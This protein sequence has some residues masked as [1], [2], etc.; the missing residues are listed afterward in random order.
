M[1]VLSK[2]ARETVSRTAAR[3]LRTKL[4]LGASSR[5]SGALAPCSTALSNKLGA[6]AAQ[7]GSQFKNSWTSASVIRNFSTE[8]NTAS[9]GAEKMEFKAETKKLLNIVAK[10]LYTDKEVFIRELISNASDA[11]E[12]LRFLQTSG[13]APE[14]LTSKDQ[15]LQ[16]EL[17]C[18][19]NLRLFTIQDYGIGMT[20]EQLIHNLG[21]IARSGSREFLEQTSTGSGEAEQQN[22][23]IIGQFGVGFYSAFVVADK[24]EVL[25]RSADA[26]NKGYKWSSDGMGEFTIE[27]LPE[28]QTP[29]RGTK[30]QLHLKEDCSEFSKL[31]TVKSCAKKFSSFVDFPLFVQEEAG[32]MKE[33]NK[34]EPL[35]LKAKATEEEHSEFYRFLSGTSYGDPYYTLSFASD[36]PLTIKSLFYVPEDAP[37][38]FFAKE[39]E[40]GVALHCRRV[41][42]KKQAEGIMPRWLHWV[43]GVVDCEDMPLNISR[44][45][46]QDTAL[47]NK[48][49]LA[50]VRRFLRF[51]DQQAKKDA[52]KYL[53][54]YKN[55]SYY[56]KAGLIEDRDQGGRHKEE[57][58]KLLR[59]GVSTRPEGEL[60][61]LQ[62]Y[63]DNHMVSTDNG[64]QKNIYYY[65]VPNR[66]TAMNSPYMEQFQE[67]GRAVLLMH[68]DIDEFVLSS[69]LDGYK[70]HKLVAIDAQGK[71]FELD[72]DE[73]K[74]S[75]T[76]SGEKVELSSAQ[77]EEL[78]TWLKDTLGQKVMEIKFTDRLVSSPAIVTSMLTPHMRK[79]MKQ[80]MAAGAGGQGGGGADAVPMTLEIS[81]KHSI[82]KTLYSIKNSNEEVAKLSAELLFDNACIAAGML[83]EPRSVLPRLNKIL[84]TMVM[85]GA[86]YDYG[87]KE[88]VGAGGGA[89]EVQQPGENKNADVESATS[90][91]KGDAKVDEK[92]AFSSTAAGAAAE[93]SAT[94]EAVNDDPT[95]TNPVD[96][97]E[98]PIW[99]KREASG[100]ERLQEVKM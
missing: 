82:V 89:G 29:A 52:Q 34:Q 40:I 43:K 30:I 66:E 60:I 50:V 93:S 32:K 64:K 16:I 27:E 9:T 28:D 81:A 90:S 36:V 63:V 62:D 80:M 17:S 69:A 57:L 61:S 79:M 53:K 35:W 41:L 83:D 38:R 14:E 87:K 2:F 97:G 13:K 95:V 51:L 23:T 4:N 74:A 72:L 19:E 3:N 85:Q 86:G 68:E 21:T 96:A 54:F 47:M 12:K 49:S 31:L 25:T 10:S 48:L 5:T 20:K 76:E 59:Y 46:M 33:L 55:Y 7:H 24:I 98:M 58:T 37:S 100:N 44:E 73:K 1:T 18:D 75:E 42:V 39:P 56:L 8:N 67:R 92:A 77:Q 22:T 71:D 88:Y 6:G 70:E 94:S 11:C 84:E 99:S 78:K 45:S 65:C 15:Q 91:S 26:S